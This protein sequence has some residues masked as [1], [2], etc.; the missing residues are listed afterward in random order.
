MNDEK[1]AKALGWASIAI[2][3]SEI[4]APG[5]LQEQMGVSDHDT[6]LR[7][8]GLREIA[9][10]VAILTSPPDSGG[11]TAGVWS[12]VAGDALDLALLGAAARTTRKPSGLAVTIAMVAGITLVDVLFAFKLQKRQPATMRDV[13]WERG[14]HVPS[15]G[16]SL[17]RMVR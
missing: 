12:R 10:G 9:E 7:S 14:R 6:L 3:L 1:V 11:V 4:A 16:G 15:L 5:F 2:G 13:G 8:M 17:S